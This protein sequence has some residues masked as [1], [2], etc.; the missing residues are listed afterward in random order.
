MA[1]TRARRAELVKLIS[2]YYLSDK[3]I[4]TAAAAAYFRVSDST[5]RRYLLL[6]NVPIRNTWSRKLSVVDGKKFCPICKQTKVVATEFYSRVSGRPYTY[7]KVCDKARSVATC[8]RNRRA[9]SDR[10]KRLKEMVRKNNIEA[11]LLL[12]DAATFIREISDYA[13]IVDRIESFFISEK[14]ML[15]LLEVG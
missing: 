4:T 15:N 6:A 8:R 5:I 13:P 2:E 1:N 3:R 12:K 7:C 11:R 10:K 9:I 14:N